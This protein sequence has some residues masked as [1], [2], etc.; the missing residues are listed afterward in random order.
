MSLVKLINAQKLTHSCL[1]TLSQR[2]DVELL[3][4]S[5]LI[6]LSESVGVDLFSADITLRLYIKLRP[7]SDEEVADFLEN[8]FDTLIT[9]KGSR[10]MVM[11]KVRVIEAVQESTMAKLSIEQIVEHLKSLPLVIDLEK[12]AYEFLQIFKIYKIVRTLADVFGEI[13][14]DHQVRGN[15]EVSL[16]D[17]RVKPL[18]LMRYLR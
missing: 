13:F 16:A 3:S 6:C 5:Q 18:G 11:P 8:F 17:R 14:I 4:P 9:E 1:V 15:V 10:N 2:E 12:E 7:Q